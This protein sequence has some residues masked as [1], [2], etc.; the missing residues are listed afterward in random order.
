MSAEQRK[1]LFA[2][3]VAGRT[4]SEMDGPV[5]LLDLGCGTG[6]SRDVFVALSAETRWRGVDIAASP[7]V[8]S[9]TGDASDIDT[10]DGV[11]LPYS[12]A[13][14]DVVYSRQVFEHVRRPHE[15]MSEVARVLKPGGYLVGSVA[16]L[17]PYH[18]LSTF[19]FTPFGMQYLI[20]QSGLQPELLHHSCDVFFTIARQWFNKARFMEFFRSKSLLYAF[21]EIVG[22]ICGLDRPDINLMKIQYCGSF[23]FVARKPA[24]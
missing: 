22:K 18:S 16:Y 23:C 8:D 5:S 12:A 14:F 24:G 19:N 15:L 6:E 4:M 2:E 7:E 10:Y 9:R 17:E 3:D 13:S 21:F 1:M 11:N 20:G